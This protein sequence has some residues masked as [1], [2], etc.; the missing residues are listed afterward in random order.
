MKY[1]SMVSVCLICGL[2]SG[3]VYADGCIAEV[4]QATSD[5]T[6]ENIVE[7]V[8]EEGERY[9]QFVSGLKSVGTVRRLSA[10]NQFYQ[11]NT[12]FNRKTAY[13]N[14]DVLEGEFIGVHFSG[15]TDTNAAFGLFLGFEKRGCKLRSV[16]YDRPT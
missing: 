9:D 3:V 8:E 12:S 7:L 4:T 6:F 10:G 14:G 1:L 11:S 5:M 13:I 2:V 16:S 15:T